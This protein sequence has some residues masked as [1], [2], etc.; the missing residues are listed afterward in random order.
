MAKL[1]AELFMSKKKLW[2]VSEL[3]YPETSATGRI[4]TQL[5]VSLTSDFEVGAICCQPSYEARGMQCPKHEIYAGVEIFRVKGGRLN[6]NVLPLRIL[7]LLMSSFSLLGKSVQ[8]ISKGSTVFVVTNPP[9]LPFLVLMACALKRARL[10]LLVHDVYPDVLTRVGILREDSVPA[11]AMRSLRRL[12]FNRVDKLVVIGRDMGDLVLKALPS[13]APKMANIPNWAD[14][15]EVIPSARV[16][17]MPGEWTKENPF[18][19][20]Y[21]G[22]IGRTHGIDLIVRAA[23][24]LG[25]S[26]RFHF[27]GSGAKKKW[28]IDEVRRLGLENVLVEDYKPKDQLSDSLGACDVSIISFVPGMSGV[29]VPSRMYNVMASARPIIAVADAESEIARV[30]SEE[31]IGWVVRPDSSVELCAVVRDAMRRPETIEAMGKR[32]RRVAEEKYG[33]DTIRQRYVRLFQEVGGPV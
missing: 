5:A 23:Q 18:V 22:N 6:K 24:E 27:I 28:L 7:N 2:I 30:V 12:L 11:K 1:E 9:A 17:P 21:A 31:E 33:F 19:V 29:S 26:V 15:E 32:A 25:D 3:F 20:Q 16:K 10:V 8:H 13:I 14:L 4:L